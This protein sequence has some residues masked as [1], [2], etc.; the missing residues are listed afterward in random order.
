MNIMLLLLLLLIILILTILRIMII[1]MM[2]IASPRAKNSA[3]SSLLCLLKLVVTSATTVIALSIN[4]MCT[5]I[6]FSLLVSLCVLLLVCVLMIVAFVFGR[7]ASQESGVSGLFDS[8]ILDFRGL[9]SNIVLSL[10]GGILMPVR[11][12]PEMSSQQILVGTRIFL[13]LKGGGSSSM[14]NFPEVLSKSNTR[15]THI[16]TG[17]TCVLALRRAGR[18][19]EEEA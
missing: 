18:G 17:I 14:G 4:V 5:C 15:Q 8:R 13:I 10:R 3:V 19:A 11:S 6:S 2:L 16:I 1:L 7:P 9:D 12:F